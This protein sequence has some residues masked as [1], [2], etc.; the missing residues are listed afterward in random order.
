MKMNPP[1]NV[2]F[3]E[4]LRLMV[5]RPRGILNEQGVAAIVEFLEK[6]EDR[7]ETPFNRFTDNSKLDAVDLNFECVFRIALHRRLFYAQRPPVKSAFYV[8]SP[9]IARIVKMHALLTNHSP[10]QVKMFEDFAS[11]AKWLG[12][13]VETLEY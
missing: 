8:N 9:A 13:S 6:E 3:H 5:Y 2:V 4:E 10:L 12:F 11:A 1:P 7:A